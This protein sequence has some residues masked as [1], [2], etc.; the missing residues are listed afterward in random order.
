MADRVEGVLRKQ[1]KNPVL[2]ANFVGN[3]ITAK[4]ANLPAICV[5]RS[6]V[7]DCLVMRHEHSKK[8]GLNPLSYINFNY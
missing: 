7:Q 3:T 8:Y 5:Q 6:D 2:K 1:E 4:N